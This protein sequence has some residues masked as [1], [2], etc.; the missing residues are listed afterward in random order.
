MDQLLNYFPQ[1][2]NLTFV[3]PSLY[4]VEVQE[5]SAVIIRLILDAGK[6]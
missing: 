3:S 4:R 6:R 2:N 5:S 1:I